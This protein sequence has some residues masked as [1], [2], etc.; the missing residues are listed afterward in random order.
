MT[1][2]DDDFLLESK[3]VLVQGK[4]WRLNERDLLC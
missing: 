3:L 2:E 4:A 1:L